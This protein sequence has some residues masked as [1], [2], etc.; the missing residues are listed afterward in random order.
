MS[1]FYS[2][3]AEAAWA[4]A[5]HGFATDSHGESEGPDG[6]NAL[7]TLNAVT[8]LNV[9]ETLLSE[10]FCSDYGEA[11]LLVWLNQ[12]AN[13]GVSVVQYAGDDTPRAASVEEAYYAS[14]N[15]EPFGD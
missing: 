13:G 1:I 10:H 4:I 11:T 3:L 14:A 8:L 6:W 5:N 7:V 2:T 9:G 12:S 15:H